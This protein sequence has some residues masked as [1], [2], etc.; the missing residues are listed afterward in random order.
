MSE[1]SECIDYLEDDELI[2][3]ESQL[4][5]LDVELTPFL[6]KRIKPKVKVPPTIFKQAQKLK[7][8]LKGPFFGRTR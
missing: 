1:T 3:M 6:G 8:W 5:Y 2:D 7:E 4:A